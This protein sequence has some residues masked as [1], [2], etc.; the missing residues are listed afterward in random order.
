MS[1]KA[2]KWM[3]NP[4]REDEGLTLPWMITI[5]CGSV[6][7]GLIFGIVVFCICRTSKPEREQ[8]TAIVVD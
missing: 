5:V 6:F 7:I 3:N 2:E 1:D 8:K 4:L